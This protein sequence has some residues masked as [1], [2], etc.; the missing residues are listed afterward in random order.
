MVR[1]DERLVEVEYHHLP[2]NQTLKIQRG[3]HYLEVQIKG[4]VRFAINVIGSAMNKC[5]WVIIAILL[6]R[7]R[8]PYSYIYISH[9]LLNMRV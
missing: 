2:P 9:R 1:V 6:C 8:N 3:T 7:N 5:D 4:N